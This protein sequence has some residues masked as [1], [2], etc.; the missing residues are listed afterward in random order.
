MQY[1]VR[2]TAEIVVTPIQMEQFTLEKPEASNTLYSLLV[3]Q[4]ELVFQLLVCL[5]FMYLDVSI[6]VWTYKYV[7]MYIIYM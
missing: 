1:S 3:L 7:N 4:L 5:Q 2:I 6:V